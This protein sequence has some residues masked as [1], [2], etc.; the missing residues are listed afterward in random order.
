MSMSR[1]KREATPL[2]VGRGSGEALMSTSR[3][4]R[5]ATR[6]EDRMTAGIFCLSKMEQSIPF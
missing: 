1:A 6:L 2:V 5:E 4:E 3:G